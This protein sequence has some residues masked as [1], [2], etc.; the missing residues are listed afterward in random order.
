[1]RNVAVYRRYDEVNDTN[2]RGSAHAGRW[3]VHVR[4][5]YCAIVTSYDSSRNGPKRSSEQGVSP[6]AG[7]LLQPHHA[8][9]AR[10]R[11][12]TSGL[13]SNRLGPRTN[14]LEPATSRA[15]TATSDRAAAT[16]LSATT[17]R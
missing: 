16:V 12:A 8:A 1:M 5:R 17:A 13:K 14:S 6:Q 2:G 11:R 10:S 7:L 9:T 15:T 3:S 4:M